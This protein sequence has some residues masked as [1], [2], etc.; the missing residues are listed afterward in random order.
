MGGQDLAPAAA[1]AG[2]CS[3]R[4]DGPGPGRG[5]GVDGGHAHL[6]GSRAACTGL[7]RP[8]LCPR[9]RMRSDDCRCIVSVGFAE[10]RRAV[11]RGPGSRTS[12]RTRAAVIEGT[13]EGKAGTCEHHDGSSRRLDDLD[14]RAVT[15]IRGLAMDAVQKVGNGHP[16]TAMSLAPL[17]YHLFQHVLRHDPADDRWVGRDRFVLSAGHSSLTLYIQLYLSGYGLELGDL[18]AFRTWGSLTPGTRS[19]GTP[20]ASRPPP[21]RSARA[22]PTRSAWR[23]PPA[24]S[25]GCSTR[26]PPPARARSTTTIYVIASDGDLEEGITSEASSIA[27]TPAAGQPARGL[28]RQPHLDRGRHR[29]RVQ[30][31]HR[32][33]VRGLRLAH[34]A[35]RRAADGRGR[36]GRLRRR[37]RRGPGR[38]RP[39]LVHRACARS[40]AGPR[41]TCA[42]PARRT[43]R[44]S[45]ADEVAATKVILGF[46][47]DKSFQVDRRGARARPAGRRSAARRRTRSGTPS[48][49]RWRSANPERAALFDRLFAGE[50]PA[51]W[52]DAVP[53]F[54][55]DPKGDGHPQGVRRGAQ[56]A[57]SGAAR[58]VGRL[59]RP[60]RVEQHHHGGRA[61]V[62]ARQHRHP[63]VGR[64]RPVRP[65]PALRHP[66][67]RDGR[68]PQRDRAARPHPPVRRHVPG[69]LRLHAR[70]GPA[71]R[72]DAGPGDVRVDARLD[73]PRRGRPHP[74]AGRA[75][76]R[77]AGD[78][79]PVRRAP[80]RRQ[81]DRGRLAD[82]PVRPAGRSGWR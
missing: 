73:R 40:S 79:G 54:P 50:R 30:R 12:S 22:W 46:D 48:C 33:P 6:P 31:G 9:R 42:T 60:R 43:A 45:G 19:T 27:G 72:A 65:H 63:A 25:A 74:P 59:R 5:A 17:A 61:V 49:E 69:V 75:P 35:R 18:E 41:R 10:G 4:P 15:T 8:F 1:A 21:A 70:G 26:T 20:R 38:H 56:R 24:A 81:R 55:A 16:G 32:R 82:D 14:D 13:S 47:P 76:G 23:W 2:R 34:P 68:D 71:G 36:R 58:A 53:T 52:T 39:A 66:R 77:A 62:P 28:G 67:A 80:R 64:R 7:V 44:R 37:R 3:A 29:D 51:G 57:R 11:R 78:P